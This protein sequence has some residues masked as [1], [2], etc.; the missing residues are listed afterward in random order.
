MG[1]SAFIPPML[2]VLGLDLNFLGNVNEKPYEGYYGLTASV[3]TG[4]GFELHVTEG[5]TFPVFKY[6]NVFDNWERVY[7]LYADKRCG[8]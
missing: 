3:A 8:M 7:N 4:E 1:G 5:N 6:V 2:A